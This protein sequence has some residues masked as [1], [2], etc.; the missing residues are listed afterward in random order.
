MHVFVIVRF[1]HILQIS[2]ELL[3]DHVF[4]LNLTLHT[5]T[6][7]GNCCRNLNWILNYLLTVLNCP[8]SHKIDCFCMYRS[9]LWLLFYPIGQRMCC[10]DYSTFRWRLWWAGLLI[11]LFLFVY[12]V[13]LSSLVRSLAGEDFPPYSRLP[14]YSTDCLPYFRETPEFVSFQCD[15]F[16]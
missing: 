2:T 7:V 15:K 4:Q 11:F 13:L 3:I 9:S 10:W 6:W 14:C 5:F 16:E 1:K 12:F 8:L